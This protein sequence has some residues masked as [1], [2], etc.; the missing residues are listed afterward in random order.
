MKTAIT[1]LFGLLAFVRV[2]SAQLAEV[3]VVS[4]QVQ[5]ADGQPVVGA[6]LAL[7]M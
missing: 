1:C 3:P 7:S 4:G 5:L 2:G 6:S